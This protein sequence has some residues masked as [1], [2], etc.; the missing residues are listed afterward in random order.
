[1]AT[2]SVFVNKTNV[3]GSKNYIPS[4]M[5]LMEGIKGRLSMQMLEL[6]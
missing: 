6:T 2:S 4:P 5:T 3:M 1:M